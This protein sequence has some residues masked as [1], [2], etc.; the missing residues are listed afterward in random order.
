MELKRSVYKKILNWRRSQNKKPLIVEGLRQ[1]GKSFLCEKLGMEEYENY[2]LYDFR[3]DKSLNDIFINKKENKLSVDS[4]IENSIVHF[5]N[6]RFVPN[7]TLLIF[8][9]INDCALARESLKI[10]AKDS[11]YDVIATGSLLGISDLKAKNIPAGYDSYI[12]VKPLDFIEFLLACGI[13]EETIELVYNYVEKNEE[14]SES[15]INILH[16]YFIRYILVG[17]MP[18][19]V[20]KYIETQNINEVR[21]EQQS[22]LKDYMHDFGTRYNEKGERYIDS[23]LLIRI[24]RA[25][26]S[27]PDQL[28]K[29]NKK[30]KYSVIKDGGR[31]SEFSDALEWLKK[32]GLIVKANNLRV[33]ESPLKGNSITEEFKVYLSDIGLLMAKYPIT[34]VEQ[35]L[36]DDLG[37]YK[38]AIYEA[39]CADILYKSNY[40]LYYFA[41]SIKHLE[42][43]FLIETTNGIDVFEVKANNGKMASAKMLYENRAQYKIHK[44]YK[45]IKKGYGKGDYFESF[46]HFLLPFF[47]NNIK[48]IDEKKLILN[49]LPKI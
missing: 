44:I 35:V 11:R 37:A 30:F 33:I 26:D 14:L 36:N 17:G 47:L 46:P 39:I 1:V 38:G 6:K 24:S 31:S 43:D 16:S 45:L 15:Y 21:D 25:F 32:I 41:D 7:K 29:E 12:E 19:V 40:D 28:A 4:I 42:N 2:V 10:F 23:T 5:P 48:E 18:E 9:E 27:I 3:H 13:K 8:D 49:E 22:L 34:I 20:K